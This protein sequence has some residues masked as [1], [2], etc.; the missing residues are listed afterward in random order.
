VLIKRKGVDYLKKAK[1]SVHKNHNIRIQ[2]L[3]FFVIQASKNK[4]NYVVVTV[5]V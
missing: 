5:F 2:R 3:K 1:K 4:K